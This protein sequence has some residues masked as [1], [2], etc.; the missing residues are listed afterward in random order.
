VRVDNPP[1][2]GVRPSGT[3]ADAMSRPTDPNKS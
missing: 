1:S 3:T 2:S